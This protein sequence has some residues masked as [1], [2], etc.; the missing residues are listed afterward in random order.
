MPIDSSDIDFNEMNK[1]DIFVGSGH[2][3]GVFRFLVKILNIMNSSKSYESIQPI[4][5]MLYKRITVLYLKIQLSRI[6]ETIL[7]YCMNL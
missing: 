4:G 3:Q 2:V 5:Y 6:L 1:I 7:M